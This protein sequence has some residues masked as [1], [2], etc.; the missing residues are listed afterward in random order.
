[1]IYSEGLAKIEVPDSK[2][3]LKTNLV[4]LNE[5][6]K[7]DRDLHV[8]LVNSLDWRSKS[9][10][11]LMSA[12]GIRPIRLAKET[13]AFSRILMNDLKPSAYASMKLNSEANGVKAELYN[14]NA[15]TLLSGLEESF[16]A[17][18]IDPFGSPIYYIRD[19]LPR[20]KNGGILSITATDTGCL[21]GSFPTA[22]ARR[23]HS[24][25]YLSEFYYESGIR[26]LAKAAIEEASIFDYA[27]TPIFCHAKRHYFR[28]YFRKERGAKK[29]D[30]LLKK[31]VI[32]SYCPYCL[33]R[34]I[35]CSKTC[36]NCSKPTVVFGPVFSGKMFDTKLL[37]E[38]QKNAGDYTEMIEQ[39]IDENS[40]DL[41][42][43]YTTDRVSKIYKLAEPSITKLNYART[44]INPKGFKT[45]ET[46]KEIVE[47]FKKL[48]PK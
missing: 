14:K 29:T 38:M 8:I 39:M 4:F 31:N 3:L 30:E 5:E 17:V 36:R 35:G 24:R 47:H 13:K 23:Y 1:M 10:L 25:S 33:Y 2:K 9:Y 48:Q 19:A 44:H 27:L 40:V 46:I 20:L 16:D 11:D 42:W 34:E 28:I 7:L 32:I 45:N 37:K 21:S 43:H 22:A 18:D 15:Q 6:K 26:I 12:S 41:P